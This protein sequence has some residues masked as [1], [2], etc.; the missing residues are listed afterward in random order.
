[1]SS[2]RRVLVT[3][4]NGFIGQ[5]LVRRCVAAGDA[6]TA[7]GH[8][9]RARLAT[10]H[11]VEAGVTSVHGSIL[12]AQAVADAFAASRPEVLFHLAAVSYQDANRRPKLAFETHVSGTYTVL[13]AAVRAGVSTVVLASSAAVYRNAGEPL[14]EDDPAH[15]GPIDTFGLS[16]L[17]MEDVGRY[18]SSLGLRTCIAARLFNVYGPHE[19]DNRLIP[20][21]VQMLRTSNVVVVGNTETA[22]DYVYLDDAAEMLHRC[23]AID[24]RG[25]VAINLGSGVEHSV[26][27]VVQAVADILGRDVDIRSDAARLRAVDRAHLLADVRKVRRTLEGPSA[28]MLRD[29]LADLLR[30]EGLT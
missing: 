6:V 24:A 13:D 11:G 19:E 8:P 27:A 26:R 17:L 9:A 16:K 22:R 25:F 3:G 30:A 10:H 15:V 29:G 1:M 7:F 5:A 2:G 12:D 28:R 18:F 23:G 21:V 4:A 20:T 14:V